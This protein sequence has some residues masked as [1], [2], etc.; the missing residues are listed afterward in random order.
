M[1]SL[2]TW[3]KMSVLLIPLRWSGDSVMRMQLEGP[4][5]RAEGPDLAL[6]PWLRGWN[7]E[8]LFFKAHNW[9]LRAP[10]LKKERKLKLGIVKV[11]F[12]LLQ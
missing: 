3:E 4:L 2:F 10:C 8:L 5:G 9:V 6:S 11:T 7:K 1:G 12:I